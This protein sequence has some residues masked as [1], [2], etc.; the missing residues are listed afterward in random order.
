MDNVTNLIHKIQL[1]EKTLYIL[2]GYP[3][4]GKSYI[5]EQIIKQ[6]NVALVSIDSIFRD[7]G[8]NWNTDTLP[9]DLEWSDIFAESY[10][11][12]KA[13]LEEG[14]SVIYDSTNQTVVSRDTLREVAKDADADAVVIY[15]TSDETT[16]WERWEKSTLD[17]S[18]HIVSKDLVAQTIVAL[19]APSEDENT[20]V[21]SN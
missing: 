16:I 15:I 9:N 20:I 5:A 10:K 17:R 3:Y 6:T 18:R 19:E 14:R 11:L 7:H 1:S 12:T 8:F 2:C 21:I 4:A 13:A